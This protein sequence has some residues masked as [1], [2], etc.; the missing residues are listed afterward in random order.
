MALLKPT[1]DFQTTVIS[2]GSQ[3]SAVGTTMTIGTGLTIP[4]TNGVLQIDY[5]STE[6]LGAASGPET[7]SYA[8]YTSGTGAITGMTRGLAGTTGV[9]HENGAS[10]QCGPSAAYGGQGTILAN[11]IGT[12]EVTQAKLATTSGNGPLKTK[13]LNFTRA[14]DGATADVSYT[15][16]GFIPSKITAI[17]VAG[18]TLYWSTGFADSTKAASVIYQGAANTVYDS[19]SGLILY[20]NF[21]GWA[22]T[23]TVKS[24]DADGFTLTWTKTG[25]PSAGTLTIKVICER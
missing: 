11:D 13:I 1:G 23:A 9:T 15:G 25:S 2:T 4:A 20:S 12:G 17:M 18:G 21:S 14:G 6:A 8:S 24:Y 19:S 22:Q 3:L 10:V 7:V 5:D 16:V